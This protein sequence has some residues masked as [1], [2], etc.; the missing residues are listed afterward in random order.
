[1][2]LCKKPVIQ[3]CLEWKRSRICSYFTYILQS[4]LASFKLYMYWTFFFQ[5]HKNEK[6]PA[7]FFSTST[8]MKKQ[9]ILRTIFSFSFLSIILNCVLNWLWLSSEIF[10]GLH[11]VRMF[12]AII[13]YAGIAR[14]VG[15]GVPHLSGRHNK[16]LFFVTLL[17]VK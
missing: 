15:S 5:E 17:A 2:I 4:S 9:G 16:K 1:M 3:S 14:K 7:D 6:S 12:D 13:N 11:L 8:Y 10:I